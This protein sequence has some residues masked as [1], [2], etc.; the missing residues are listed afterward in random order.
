MFQKPKDQL[1][2]V[3]ADDSKDDQV[4]L[5]RAFAAAGVPNPLLFVRDG[6]ELITQL[7]AC[8]AP[9]GGGLP[10]IVL[11]DL[12]MPRMDG[13]EALIS[14]RSDPRFALL[15]VLLLSTTQYRDDVLE[16]YRAGANSVITKPF[17]YEEFVALAGILHAYWMGHVELPGIYGSR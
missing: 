8:V 11:M 15:P 6:R 12:K 1:R 16:C 7:E 10:G 9:G 5:Q 14:I 2:I 3:V 17:S 13:K 4:L